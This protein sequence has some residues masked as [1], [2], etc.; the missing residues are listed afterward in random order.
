MALIDTCFLNKRFASIKGN[1]RVGFRINEMWGS[2]TH[3][4]V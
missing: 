2:C 3:F 1:K 4:S